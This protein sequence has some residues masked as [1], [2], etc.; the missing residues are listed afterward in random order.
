VPLGEYLIRTYT[1]EDDLV[2]DNCAGSGSFLVAA[3]NTGRNYIG[4]EMDE[5]FCQIAEERL[6]VSLA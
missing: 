4:I 5:R 3:K 2:L 1:N 6:K